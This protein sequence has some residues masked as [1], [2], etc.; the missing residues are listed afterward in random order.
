MYGTRR[1]SKDRQ[2]AALM[3]TVMGVISRTRWSSG[4]T[5][6]PVMATQLQQQLTHLSFVLVTEG[7]AWAREMPAWPEFR[8][9]MTLT[10]AVS[11]RLGRTV[12]G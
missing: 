12:R 1:C 5:L 6:K 3:V 9:G 2:R 10:E 7:D 4:T 8:F 11:A